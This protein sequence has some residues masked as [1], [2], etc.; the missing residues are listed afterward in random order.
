MFDVQSKRTLEGSQTKIPAASEKSP[1]KELAGQDFAAQEAALAPGGAVQLRARGNVDPAGI[2]ATAAEGVRGG[3]GRM[4]HFDRIQ[5]SFGRH[6]IGAVQAHVGGAARDA[7]EQIGASAYATGDNVAFRD[8]PDLFTAAH[9]AAHVVQQKAGVDLPSGVGTVGDT[10]EKNADAVASKVVAGE[11]AEALLGA[12]ANGAA[13]NVQKR[14][15]AVQRDD[16][17]GELSGPKVDSAIKY[18]KGKGFKAA[19]W[20]QI[21]GVVGSS[22]SAIDETLVKAIAAWQAKQGMPSDGKVGNITMGWLAQ[23]PGGKGL[24][25]KVTSNNILYVGLNPSSK[26]KEHDKLKGVGANVTAV[27]GEKEQGTAKVDGETKNLNT[28]EGLQAFI[29]SLQG[30]IDK[31]RRDLLKQFINTSDFAAKDEVA[32]IAKALNDA[33]AGRTIF[34]RVIL[35][36]HSGGWSFWG[37]DN[38]EIT[39]DH[40]AKLPKIFPKAL[41]CVQ[42]LMLSACNTGQKS[43]LKRYRAI[44]PNVKSIWAYVGY[45][46]SAASGAL[47]HI[48]NWEQ[49]TRGSLDNDKIDKAR[50]K[51]GRRGGKNDKNVATLTIADDGTEEY[52]TDSEKALQSYDTLKGLVDSDMPKYE[53]AMNEGS[54][55]KQALSTFYT[56]LQNLLG[57]FAYRV[58]NA[59]EMQKVLKRTL[60]LRYW[61]NVTKK[62]MEA[63]GST[64]KSGYEAAGGSMPHYEGASRDKVLGWVGA[65]PKSGDEAHGLLDRYLV[66]LDPEVLPATWA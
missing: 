66:K 56:N 59:E 27:K 28:D 2:Q 39:F 19:V 16:A 12:P 36:G 53:K 62:F 11:S 55:D 63:H 49:A 17:P 57:N 10:Y 61:E 3:G 65:Y 38:G 24:E 52:K 37:D 35:S 20:E 26:N 1:R 8:Q 54:I 47:T 60:F 40:M 4:P 7:S 21:A 34:T 46:P 45:S 29:D 9:E 6:D 22:S 48:G 13:S 42:D 44:F 14:T 50:S 43:K 32:Q 64:V 5:A 25:N 15:A 31:G 41:G 23:E 33:E 58:P 18:N 30:G 51:T